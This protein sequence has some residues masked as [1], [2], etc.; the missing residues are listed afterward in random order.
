MIK[1]TISIILV[2]ILSISM[3]ACNTAPQTSTEEDGTRVTHNDSGDT[4]VYESF[5]RTIIYNDYALSLDAINFY[6][7][8]ADSNGYD[9]NML[10]SLRFDLNDLTDEEL[11]WFQEDDNSTFD[12][13]RP[14]YSYLNVDSEDNKFDSENF[15]LL[16]TIF[17]D[18]KYVVYYY[19]MPRNYRYSLASEHVSISTRIKP[20]GT[21]E[22][23]NDEGEVKYLDK[24]DVYYYFE[25]MPETLEN[26]DDLKSNFPLE[27]E[28]LITELGMLKC[29]PLAFT[30]SLED[31]VKILPETC[32]KT[33][34]TENGFSGN[35]YS[36]SG[37]VKEILD[38]D[39]S[40]G[41]AQMFSIENEQ[42]IAWFTIADPAFWASNTEKSISDFDSLMDN[43]MDYTIPQVGEYVIVY[44]IYT[45][46]S[47]VYNA[48]VLFFGI[49]E[50][51]YDI[52]NN[53]D[54]D[55]DDTPTPTATPTATPTPSATPEPTTTVEP[56]PT[57]S[58]TTFNPPTISK[59][60]F[61]ALTNGMSYEEAVNIIG[62]SGE[63]LSEAGSPGDAYYTVMYTWKGE[64]DLGANANAMFQDN[65]LV[66]KAQYGLK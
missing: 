21:Y 4:Y 45:G 17:L 49:D 56:T 3:C 14:I 27:Y 39:E 12:I 38:K 22:Y 62:G 16:K 37:T 43:T 65:K 13:D 1:K 31:E 40:I 26:L 36:V 34:A 41:G 20:G 33:K 46:F 58:G 52:V 2:G 35:V 48:P 63:V 64:G 28:I 54:D 10:I 11:Y 24:R 66:N 32:Y 47:D 53:D 61:N 15:E 29:Y 57:T 59:T 44:G 19:T 5:P 18:N 8:I 7:Y 60:E 55:V 30:S 25:D 6:E 50:F 51:V 9:K 23:T 42:G